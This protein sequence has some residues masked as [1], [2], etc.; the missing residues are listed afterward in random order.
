MILLVEGRPHGQTWVKDQLKFRIV[1]HTFPTSPHFKIEDKLSHA[2]N[3][4]CLRNYRSFNTTYIGETTRN[5]S[6]RL[7]KYNTFFWKSGHITCNEDHAPFQDF[8]VFWTWR[9]ILAAICV[10]KYKA[11]YNIQVNSFHLLLFSHGVNNNLC[12]SFCSSFSIDLKYF[13][14]LF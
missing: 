14:C 1:G 13:S 12:N 4:V 10:A 11:N 5:F 8:S 9:R 7:S 3:V 6:I 2:S